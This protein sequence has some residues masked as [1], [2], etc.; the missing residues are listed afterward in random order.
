M[1]AHCIR[2]VAV[3]GVTIFVMT[4]LFASSDSGFVNDPMNNNIPV[5]SGEWLAHL[6]NPFVGQFN[7]VGT[8]SQWT[9]LGI[10]EL[11]F[12]SNLNI[13][14]SPLSNENSLALLHLSSNLLI[15]SRFHSDRN[16]DPLTGQSDFG[17]F[18]A[19]TGLDLLDNDISNGNEQFIPENKIER[20]DFHGLIDDSRIATIEFGTHRKVDDLQ[21]I[22]PDDDT[23]HLTTDKA[24]TD[25]AA[26]TLTLALQTDTGWDATDGITQTPVLV[27]T[28]NSQSEVTRV[29]ASVG[30]AILDITNQVQSDGSFT[31]DE[32]LLR[33]LIGGPL[34]D[35]TYSISV[36][37]EDRLGNASAPVEVSMTLDRTAAELLL[38]SPLV[39]GTHSGMVHLL[40]STDEA[41][42]LSTTLNDG[43]AVDIEVR[44]ILDQSLQ[45]LPLEDGAHQL[46]VHFSDVAG[47]VTEQVINFEVDGSAFVIGSTDTISWAAT[48][49]DEILLNEGNS[50]I[51]QAQMPISLSQS[52]GS[53][54][55]RFA[56]DAD[57][58][59][60]DETAAS[61]DTLAVYLVS[62]A[63]PG[64]T[65]LDNGTFGTPVFSLTG[66]TAHFTPGLVTYDGQYVEID[67]TALDAETEGMLVFQLLN[68]DGDT[69]S[70]IHIS[71]LT[72][73]VDPEGTEA[74]RF[75]D[76]NT[77]VTL[78]SELALENLSV[79]TA[80]EPVFSKIRF[81]AEAGEYTAHLQLRNSG[82]TS[83]SRQA[84]VVFDL[85]PDGASLKTVSGTDGDGNPYV[86]LYHAIRPG[87][88]AAGGLSDA[89]AITVSNQEQLQL[90]LTPQVLVGGPNQAPVFDLIAPIEVMPGQRIEIPLNA[91]DP[92]GDRVT[93]SLRTDTDLPNGRLDGTGTLSFEPTPNDIGTYSFTVIATDGAE[94]V[95]QTV[96]LNVV[97]DPIT[98]T[99]ISGRV[100]DTNGAPLANLPIELGRLQTVS[101]AE[102]YFILTIPET[103]FPTDEL[104]IAV[105]FGD[106]A[107]DP[108]FTGTQVIDLR[109]TT[110]DG[111][112]GTDISNPLRHPNLVSAYM[113]AGMVYGNDTSTANALRTLNG[114]G[115]LKVSEN[116]LL[117]LN[118]T[119]FFPDGP[120][121]NSNRSLNDP[122]TLFAT[123]D[124]RAN[125][126]ISLTA[127]HTV[128]VREHNRLATEIQAANPE[129]SG[130]EIYNQARKQVA[131]QIQ[132][133]TYSEYLPLLIGSDALDT[134]TGYDET[135][136]PAISH[137]FSAA[138]FR[139]G[140]TQSFSE[141]LLIDDNGE[142]LPSV[143]LRE[144]TFNP[145]IIHQYGIDAILRGLYAQLAEA[146]DTKVIDELRNTLF[147]PPGAG[148]IDLAAVDIERGRD[149]GL[150]DYNQARID[151]GLAPVTSFAEITSDLSVQAILE[152]LYDTV[153]DIDVIVGGLAEDHVSGAMVGE[154]F[155]TIIAD[156]FTRLRDG[157][158]FWYENG[159]F[160]QAELDDIR[161]T[162]LASLIQRNT[163]ITSL[164]DYV[165]SNQGVPTA[166]EAAGTVASE[167]VTEYGAIDGSGHGQ[168]GQRLPG[169][170]M[171]VNYT[172]EYGDGIRSVAGETRPNTREI[173]NALFA[174]TE[175]IPDAQG[176]TGFMLAWSQ[177]MGHDLSFS[178][179][180]AAD[181]LK[182]YGTEYESLTGEEFPYV[183]EKIDLVLGHSLYA[184]VNN[185]IERPIYLPALDIVNNEQTTDDQ[186]NI[187]VTNDMLGAEVFVTANSLDDREGNPFEGQLTISEVPTDLTPAALPE[188]LSP[189][190]VVTI[191]PGEMAFETPAQLTLPNQAGWPVGMEME[192]WS[193]NPTTGDFEVVGTGVVSDDGSSVKTVEG[194]IRNSS[195]HFFAPPGGL[196]NLGSDDPRNPDH[197]CGSTEEG[198]PFT[199]NVNLASGGI[200]ETHELISYQSLGTSR[201]VT[202]T[203]DSLRADPSPIIH[204]N[205]DIPFSSSGNGP[206]GSRFR[207]ISKLSFKQGNFEYEVPGYDGGQYGLEGGE[208]FWNVPSLGTDT[209]SAKP[210]IQAN[211]KDLASGVY[212]YSLQAGLY[213]L[214]GGRFSGRSNTIANDIVHVNGTQSQ[215]GNGWGIAGV[216]ELI[217]NA[218]GSVLIIDGNG[219]EI[220]FG[221]EGGYVSP[222]GNF[223]T[224]R[225]LENGTFEKITKEQTVY[226]FN[227]NNRLA[228]ITDRNGNQ[229]QHIYNAAEQLI[230]IIDPVGLSTRFEY[231]NGRISKIIDPAERETIL[232]Y[233]VSGNLTRITDPDGTSRQFAYDNKGHMVGETDKLGYQEKAVYDF[234]GRATQA[235]G[236]DGRIIKVQPPQ[237]E[238]LYKPE[239]TSENPLLAPS[240]PDAPDDS[241]VIYS[242]GRGQVKTTNLDA[243]GQAISVRDQVGTQYTVQRNSANLVEQLSTE[244]NKLTSFEYDDRGNLIR[245]VDELSDSGHSA[246]DI[247]TIGK[248]G[249]GNTSPQ[250]FDNP[251]YFPVVSP[252]KVIAKDVNG[253]EYLDLVSVNALPTYGYGPKSSHVSVFF[254]D[255]QGRFSGGSVVSFEEQLDS[256][257][258]IAV[259]DFDGDGNQDIV[260]NDSGSGDRYFAIAFGN[261]DGTFTEELSIR[262][263]NRHPYDQRGETIIIHD[264]D[265]DG[266]KDILY[267]TDDEPAIIFGNPDGILSKQVYLETLNE[268]NDSGHMA[269]ADVNGDG[270]IDIVRQAKIYDLSGVEGIEVFLNQGDR[271]F[272]API[273]HNTV[274]A[275]GTLDETNAFTIADLDADGLDDIISTQIN[276]TAVTVLFG[277]T[278]TPLSRVENYAADQQPHQIR[279]ADLNGDNQLD[280]VTANGDSNTVSILLNTDTGFTVATDYTIRDY[281][282]VFRSDDAISAA[283]DSLQLRDV[284]NDGH[285]DILTANE[286]DNS[287]SVLLNR[288]DGSFIESVNYAVGE[289]PAAL[290]LDDFNQDGFAD[291]AVANSNASNGFISILLNQRNGDFELTLPLPNEAVQSFETPGG[292]GELLVAD[293]NN[294]GLDDLLSVDYLNSIFLQINNADAT[295]AT[296]IEFELG[297]TVQSI[298][299]GD[300]NQDGTL[301]ILAS[302][303]DYRTQRSQIV[304]IISNESRALVIETPWSIDGPAFNVNVGDFNGDSI[305][306]FSYLSQDDNYDPNLVIWLGDE[307]GT[308]QQDSSTLISFNN[309]YD[310]DSADV[311]ITQIADINNDGLDDLVYLREGLLDTSTDEIFLSALL[312]NGDGSFTES[313]SQYISPG[314]TVYTLL[315]N[316]RL[317][318]ADLNG[319]GSLDIALTYEDKR[320]RNRHHYLQT[321]LGDGNGSFSVQQTQNITRF[322]GSD[323]E[324]DLSIVDINNDQHADLLLIAEGYPNSLLSI[325]LG[326]GTGL[327]DFQDGQR[328]QEYAVLSSTDTLL[329]GNF[330]LDSD[331]DVL[332]NQDDKNYILLNRLSFV[333]DELEDEPEAPLTTIDRRDLV[334]A[335]LFTYDDTFSQLTSVTDELGSTTLFTI[336]STNGNTVEMRQVLGEVGGSDDIVTVY[337]YTDAG[338]VDLETDDLGRVKDYD[339]D[340]FGRLVK[341]I[342]AKG[343]AS[344]A[345]QLFSYDAAGNLTQFTDENGNVT[346]YKYD[347]MNRLIQ[348]VDADP[349]GAGAQQAPV[350]LFGYDAAGNLIE[351][352]DANGNTTSFAYDPLNRL[353]QR[354]D[355][356]DQATEYMYDQAGNVVAMTT[357]RGETTNY[358][359]DARN[360]LISETD[361]EGGITTYQYD[362]DNNLTAIEDAEGNRTN[363]FY[364]A[365]QRLIAI[366][367][368][369]GRFTDYD[370][371]AA[372]NL[373]A[374]RDRNGHITRYRYD[375]LNRLIQIEDAEGNR[376]QTTYDEVGNIAVSIDQ[377]GNETRYIYDERNRLGLT[378]DALGGE[379]RY[380]YDGVGNVLSTID[381]LGRETTYGY[382]AL[383]RLTQVTDPLNHNTHYKYDGVG[384]LTQVAG[385]LGRVVNYSYDN[386]NRQI[387]VTDAYGSTTRTHYDGVGNVVAVTDEL[388]RTTRYDY[389]GRNWLTRTADALGHS[390]TYDY[391]RV[392]NLIALTDA[393]GHQTRYEYDNLYRQTNTIDALGKATTTTYD[394]E[395][396]ILSLTDASGN[397]TT[398]AYDDIHQLMAEAITIDGT[399]LTRVYNYD[400]AGNL[401]E[402]I[403]R[404]GR[405]QAYEYDAL[406]RLE[407]EQWLDDDSNP[408]RT[409]SY[410]YDAASQLQSLSDPDAVYAYNYDLAGRLI[411][412]DNNNTPGVPHVIFNYDYD[413]VNNLTRVADSIEGIQTGL[414]S[415][416]YDLLNRATQITQSGNGVT[417]KRVDIAYDAVSQMTGL[418]RYSDLT[419]T[420]LV[421]QTVYDYDAAGRITELIHQRGTDIIANY[422]FSYNAANHLT[423][424]V[425]PDGTSDYSYNNRNELTGADHSYRENEAYNYDATGNRNNNMTGDYNR[426]LSDGAYT[427]E[428]DNEGNRTRRVDIATGEVTDY[429]WDHRNRLTVAVTTNSAGIITKEIAYTY[430]AYDRR[431]AKVVDPDGEGDEA[432]TEERFVYDGDHIALVFDGDGNQTHRYLH[433]PRIDQVLAEETA[434]RETRWALTDHQGSVRGVIDNQ[435]TV[436]NHITYNSFGQVT[437]QSNP[438]AY[439]RFG[440]TGRELDQESGQY[441]YRARYYDPSVGR[442]ISEDPIGFDA[443][444]ANL[445]RYVFN[446][447]PNYVDPTGNYI[448]SGWDLLSLGVGVV[449]LGVNIRR[450]DWKNAAIDGVGITADV[451][452]LLLPVP[453]GVSA[454]RN[455]DK[456]GQVATFVNRSQSLKRGTDFVK[457]NQRAKNGIRGAQLANL[458]ASIYQTGES[459]VQAYRNWRDSCSSDIP[460]RAL[461]QTGLSGLGIL[462]ARNNVRRS[463]QRE[464]VIA[465]KIGTSKRLI[466]SYSE[467]HKKYHQGFKEYPNNT[468]IGWEWYQESATTNRTTII[469]RLPDIQKVFSEQKFHRLNIRQRPGWKHEVNDAWLQGV[470]DAGKPVKLVSPIKTKTLLRNPRPRPR[471]EKPIS[472]VYRRE[473]NQL[474]KAGYTIHSG[475]AIPPDAT[476]L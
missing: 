464:S 432:P 166:P 30:E 171:G 103:S 366:R 84:A 238:G 139:M 149:V 59:F 316:S 347:V 305:L 392:G 446:S 22:N 426:L 118:N 384:N 472:T 292:G 178:P 136:D 199:S 469:G 323:D 301:D 264:L 283:P 456:I 405:T 26:P 250:L 372:D 416:S 362:A 6:L 412:V 36:T 314:S 424:L 153:N 18:S 189:D 425:T 380:D 181:T 116:N 216:Q 183:A 435:G 49:D 213:A 34:V 206:T 415:F 3:C 226:T 419:G 290:T 27:G 29:S 20:V 132:H 46:T 242:D 21:H 440:Y 128:F 137:L 41:G 193:I 168:P 73:T 10:R 304:P 142:A 332:L 186:G 459:G 385:E 68:Q 33:V 61:G 263:E 356:D 255:A 358:Q 315:R 382:D 289:Q 462:G 8:S 443:G 450:R 205:V 302:T 62:T 79:S 254:G 364:D 403:D 249:A 447:S 43:I 196:N 101:D 211:L 233:D 397:V 337:T 155:Q 86:N 370:Y 225:K 96:T 167:T 455:A 87:G 134:Y 98:T 162:T 55:L 19:A 439:F 230:E 272:S 444:D 431:L 122:A 294:D 317:E 449:S 276:I 322:M 117:P 390:T 112:T 338:L 231:A 77:V 47:N 354:L 328:Y 342:L 258:A 312:S 297:N 56:V 212:E 74:L 32:S 80:I 378:T 313:F 365:R 396:N 452:A 54:T 64:Q 389:D 309:L 430:D 197:R 327:F 428:Y 293:F 163:D 244:R 299:T 204:F 359:Y 111:T 251:G 330:N 106:R 441:F 169:D 152:Q 48:T 114:N 151:M 454:A 37:A 406:N 210:A 99:R 398:Y 126:N 418:T 185:V 229:T 190:L 5:W 174:Q 423:Q 102:G 411:Q 281:G 351:T 409:I 108:F 307:T 326:N 275:A 377:R 129:L 90:I 176:G 97:P 320:Y 188:G 227:S 341:L 44:D 127:M 252:Q 288:G 383:S 336:D 414:E 120:L 420:Q 104:D 333:S 25:D 223:S 257:T 401:V 57:F 353:T 192:L 195:W 352:T 45:A 286:A 92:D 437:N 235:I 319:D 321:F 466:N 262:E 296:P 343:T 157:D 345:T 40:G 285:V 115:Q 266:Y 7:G 130:D 201:G 95:E 291:I 241:Q 82:K 373:V 369:T 11:L 218:D 170:L 475:W 239:E 94:T 340:S 198:A 270:Q 150:P 100:L 42:I 224:L 228:S 467:F 470:I 182:F 9:E 184:G 318:L 234:A 146:I 240:L 442:F 256:G 374:V 51:T 300:L 391:D 355:A 280:I 58:D 436:V 247:V 274:N 236:K 172:Q 265:N 402:R 143:S 350:T 278:E 361:A 144:S 260:T 154:L 52:E 76:T 445:Y 421:A 388:G 360:R 203:Y 164:P 75:E 349:D 434:D 72:N 217:E 463:F 105:P 131:A 268:S 461:I 221:N 379:I 468:I 246:R 471:D 17:K 259:D 89:I 422:S 215:I 344:E 237:V 123:G 16:T 28:V 287:L 348:Q 308:F 334:N 429:I 427:Y 125:E 141:F 460:W 145:E 408:T 417:D 207:V 63:D 368:A 173:S 24:Q 220:V 91:V 110:F 81:D 65:L 407:T 156:Q 12:S 375:Y 324:S 433:G 15:P 165:F 71:Q 413:A 457:F 160:T 161:G 271:N 346:A 113:N 399:D 138:A 175:S 410:G 180:G 159:Q 124:V 298:T 331:S 191:Q 329:T 38:T 14:E 147:G 248:H 376:V 60:T 395:G 187:T 306:D 70:R 295:F 303:Y 393:L 448:E 357:A 83:I 93:Y 158:R 438:T 148:G 214:S 85:L 69:G 202:L 200:I 339:Y 31:L 474:K 279:V 451:G 1:V 267:N 363:Y 243:A 2:W 284:N 253:D 23:R 453:G 465:N 78:G 219:S 386:L 194:G 367:D 208:H 107:F 121:P 476:S 310:Y 325:L 273:T 394:Y 245:L 140:H 269:L 473:L 67:L 53:R 179:A 177:F 135:A 4:N 404:N 39:N 311:S 387:R 88:L 335:K 282:A 209:I 371:D 261:G 119:E 35:G 133:I 13:E 232:E 50:F 381:E 277:D 222:P 66:D 400:A 458:G 109:R